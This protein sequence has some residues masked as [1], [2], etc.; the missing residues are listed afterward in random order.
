M[1]VRHLESVSAYVVICVLCAGVHACDRLFLFCSSSFVRA[2]LPPR[3]QGFHSSLYMTSHIRIHSSWRKAPP[4]RFLCARAYMHVCVPSSIHSF[5]RLFDSPLLV[6][7]CNGR[8]ET[9]GTR[10]AQVPEMDSH[11]A[12]L[13]RL[14]KGSL[15]FPTSLFSLYLSSSFRQLGRQMQDWKRR[16]DLALPIRFWSCYV[17]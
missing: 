10:F 8:I 5:L 14:L 6:I 12:A 9:M 7:V 15:L 13:L 11:N 1:F 4:T 2:V 3:G 16:L 17:F